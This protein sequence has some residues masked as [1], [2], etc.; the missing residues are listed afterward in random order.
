MCVACSKHHLLGCS[1]FA[2][3]VTPRRLNEYE[4]STE[5]FQELCVARLTASV[6]KTNQANEKKTPGNSS[7]SRHASDMT[8]TAYN[9]SRRT[10]S[11][12]FLLEEQS[13]RPRHTDLG[14]CF[15]TSPL[16]CVSFS[17]AHSTSQQLGT[18][19]P[20][21]NKSMQVQTK[22]CLSVLEHASAQ[23]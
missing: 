18:C 21:E 16:Q 6:Q 4:F 22:L 7:N 5:P 17:G 20:N 19:A 10:L 23:R 11:A 8:V 14:T 3:A 12:H 2:H 13:R 15:H 9:Q 1:S